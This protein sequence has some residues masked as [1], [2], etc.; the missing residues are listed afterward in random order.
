MLYHPPNNDNWD[1]IYDDPKEVVAPPSTAVHR[2]K[3]S[4][5]EDGY[6]KVCNVVV[7]V[8]VFMF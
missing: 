3:H 1:D 5:L 8:V 7:G 2:L 6:I 4:R